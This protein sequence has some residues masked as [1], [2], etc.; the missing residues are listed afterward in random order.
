[1]IIYG[2]Q[3]YED[4]FSVREWGKYPS[5]EVIR[6]FMRAKNKLITSGNDFNAL[7][8][9]CGIG[10]CTWFMAKEGAVVTAM[11]GAPSGLNKVTK[12][13]ESFGI[14]KN[15]NTVHGDITKPLTFIDNKFSIILDSYALY[16]NIEGHTIR[17]YEECYELLKNDGFFLTCCFGKKTHGFGTGDKISDNTYTNVKGSLSN[18]GVQTF[19]DKEYL[20]RIFNE[21][22]YRV[23]YYENIIEDRNGDLVEKHITCLS[24]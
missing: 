10:A 3:I 15:I 2:D 18:G 20:L 4:Q 7:D 11:D 24:K 9:G 12:L 1:M 22:G 14:K 6:F 5:E 17:G 23:E 16:S 21:I 8:I 13:A 19:F